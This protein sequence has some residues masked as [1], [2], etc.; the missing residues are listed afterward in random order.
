MIG[1]FTGSVMLLLI[2][3]SFVG[4]IAFIQ[5]AITI[6]VEKHYPDECRCAACQFD[7]K[8]AAK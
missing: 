7:R 4:A 1:S 5:S 3:D 2:I 6:W 8:A